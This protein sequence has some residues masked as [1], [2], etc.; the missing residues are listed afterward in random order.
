MF[1]NYLCFVLT[2]ASYDEDLQM[3]KNKV[4]GGTK[5]DDTVLEVP[6]E[7]DGTWLIHIFFAL[8]RT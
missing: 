3:K 5:V 7:P 4:T 8:G 2:Y 6:S 1:L